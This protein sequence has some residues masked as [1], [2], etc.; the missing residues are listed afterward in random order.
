V[1]QIEGLREAVEWA[2]GTF[3]TRLV[4]V[5]AFGSWARGETADGSDVD[6]LVVLERRVRLSRSLYRKWDQAPLALGGRAIDVSFAHLPPVEE[7][8][9]GIWAEV[10]VD[11]VVLLDVD[12]RLSRRLV[13]VRHDVVE[14]R[15]VRRTAHGQGYWIDVQ[16]A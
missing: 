2:L 1:E 14:G 3:E 13:R 12:L 9:A 15:I 5:A 16:A 6:V 8:V 7:T 10:A 4:A 11:G